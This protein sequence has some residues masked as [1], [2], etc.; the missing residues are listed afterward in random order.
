[1]KKIVF[2]VTT[3]LSQDQRMNRICTSLANAG[4]NV[5]LVGR[6][7]R[8]SKPLIKKNYKQKRLF[9]FFTKGKLFY[10]EYNLRLFFFLLFQKFDILCGI[11]L[12]TIL[13]T[14]IIAKIRRKIF[15]YDA[16]EYFTEME[17]VVTRPLIKKA[18][19][20]LEKTIVPRVKYGYTVSDGYSELFQKKYNVNYEIIRNATVLNQSPITNHQSPISKYILYQGSVN[21]GRGLE[22]LVEAMRQIDCQ[23]YICGKGDIL[24]DLKLY[25]KK[26]ELENKINFLGFVEPEPLKEYTRNATLGITLFSNFGLSNYYSLANRFFDYLHSGVPQIAMSY[27]EYKNFNKKHE[28]ALLIHDLKT[29]TIVSAVNKLLK[30]E[31]FYNKLRNNCL[32]ARKEFNWQNE[33]K[34]L[35]RFYENIISEVNS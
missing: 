27:P 35:L 15:V 21:V 6:E 16:H 22:N 28:V 3:E 1:M 32:E 5:L 23:L 14:F 26:L 24:E 17:E 12:D 9:C 19:E 10:I 34:K 20:W 7:L 11:D 13:P 29:E 8:T 30:D 25:A 2:T 18:W 4:Y 31:E 33:E